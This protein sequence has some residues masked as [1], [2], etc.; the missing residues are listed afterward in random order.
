MNVSKC[1]MLQI[2]LMSV[3]IAPIRV[4]CCII[5]LLLM[6]LLARIGLLCINDET[7]KTVPHSGWRKSLQQMLYGIGKAVVFCCGFHN[8]SIVGEKV[9]IIINIGFH[10]H[11]I[12]FNIFNQCK[13]LIIFL[14]I[15]V[16]T[17]MQQS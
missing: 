5:L 13:D 16:H 9:R 15:S 6:W 10:S 14:P 4:L 1:Q 3:T 7:L 17:K 12:K 8:V 2:V 11:N